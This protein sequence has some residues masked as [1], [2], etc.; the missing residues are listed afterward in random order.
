MTHCMRGWT[1][2]TAMDLDR[3][4]PAGTLQCLHRHCYASYMPAPPR[5]ATVLPVLK[6]ALCYSPPPS[7]AGSASLRGSSPPPPPPSDRDRH[8]GGGPRGGGHAACDGAARARD[9]AGAPTS[10]FPASACARDRGSCSCGNRKHALEA[11]RIERNCTA[12]GLLA[13]VS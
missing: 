5:G 12:V 6:G 11:F 13:L 2:A 10:K 4:P 8:H 3:R 1:S 7:G 9:H